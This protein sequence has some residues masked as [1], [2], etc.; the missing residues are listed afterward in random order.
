MKIPNQHSSSRSFETWPVFA[1]AA[2]SIVFAAPN[3]SAGI[4]VAISNTIV[5]YSTTGTSNG[6]YV[7]LPAGSTATGMA[8][9]GGILYIAANNSGTGT[10]YKFN[11]TTL[12]LTVFAT[13]GV[14]TP[15]QQID[16]ASDGKL[17]F[18]VQGFGIY[19]T[20]GITTTQI[21]ASANNT[22]GLYAG[23]SSYVVWGTAGSNGNGGVRGYGDLSI[24]NPGVF[25]LVGPGAAVDS[26]VPSGFYYV[27]TSITGGTEGYI[28]GTYHNTGKTQIRT[29]VGYE[30]RGQVLADFGSDDDIDNQVTGLTTDPSG[31]LY[32]SVTTNDFGGS[33]TSALYSFVGQTG[34]PTL[35]SFVPGAGNI[36][37]FNTDPVTAGYAGWA[38]SKGLN[39]LT[40]G[41]PGV[42]KDEDG[43]SNLEEY[44]FYTEP[45]SGSSIPVTTVNSGGSTVSLTY[46]RA[47]QATDVSYTAESS[48]D[49]LVWSPAGVTDAPT[50]VSDANTV[51][52]VAT[53]AKGSAA[54]KFLRIKVVLAT[55]AP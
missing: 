12:G 25:P 52:Y 30:N 13:P 54:A 53:V 5:D 17:Y 7:T 46:L 11:P 16:F 36:L 39:P 19:S 48:T 51:Q 29:G 3:A 18:A 1:I 37:Y 21:E 4:L 47:I 50:G 42:D 20:D 40:D 14:G 23:A 31:N 10:I 28:V 26:L 34:V 35:L 22:V 9:S 15:I 45:T 41:A 27:A 55:A 2:A 38:I 24:A 32:A 49:L 8:K 44:A 6:V 43:S 33:P